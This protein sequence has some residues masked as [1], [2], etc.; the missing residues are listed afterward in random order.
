MSNQCNELMQVQVLLCTWHDTK[1]TTFQAML[2]C[3][4]LAYNHRQSHHN[5][6]NT[7][8]RPVIR[9]IT[10]QAA[11]HYLGHHNTNRRPN[12]WVILTQPTAHRPTIW[13]ITLPAAGPLSESLQHKPQ[14]HNLSDHNLSTCSRPIIIW[15]MNK[16]TPERIERRNI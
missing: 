5:Y 4:I 14:A 10:T 3:L 2:K 7:I 16:F 15:F 13:V 6:D 12:I 1:D 11:S 9:V 8:R